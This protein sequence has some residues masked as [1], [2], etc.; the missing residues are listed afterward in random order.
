MRAR[1]LA[2]ASTHA[3][4]ALTSASLN[5]VCA[6]IGIGPHLPEPPAL[7]FFTSVA[8]A[9]FCPLYFL[10]TSRNAGPTTL[11]SG[12]WHEKQAFCCA[13]SLLANAGPAI[14]A[15]AVSNTIFILVSLIGCSE[16]K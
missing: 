1:H 10:L 13:S 8:S 14:S 6:G 4:S 12:A 7:M 3:A 15:A 9:S 16:Y 11:W 5:A 2:P